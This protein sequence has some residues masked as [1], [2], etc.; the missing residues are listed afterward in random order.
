[1]VVFSNHPWMLL[2]AGVG[3]NRFLWGTKLGETNVF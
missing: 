1:M 3:H 2:I